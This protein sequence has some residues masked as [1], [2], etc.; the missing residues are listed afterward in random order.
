MGEVNAQLHALS[1]SPS[2]AGRP[3]FSPA[4]F[5]LFISQVFG[6]KNPTTQNSINW[7]FETMG[8]RVLLASLSWP[9]VREGRVWNTFCGGGGGVEKKNGTI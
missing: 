6:E 1:L 2:V 5:H 7:S 3:V 9:S 4:A 8:R